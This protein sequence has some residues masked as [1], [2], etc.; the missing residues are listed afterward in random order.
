MKKLYRSKTN[1]MLLGVCGG[2]GEYLNTDPTIVR[3]VWLFLT[4]LT[5]FLPFIIVYLAA[6]IIIPEKEDDITPSQNN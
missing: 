5:G 2:L 3:L 4:A 1:R 6:A